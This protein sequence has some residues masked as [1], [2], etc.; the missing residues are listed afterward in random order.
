MFVKEKGKKESLLPLAASWFAKKQR[1]K[2]GVRGRRMC[3]CRNFL[4]LCYGSVSWRPEL[5][6]R[7]DPVSLQTG[8][9]K[10]PLTNDQDDE[11]SV[12]RNDAM[13]Y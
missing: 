5:D 1:N 4:A 13:E 12:A 9:T 2:G 8:L 6:F 7:I 10:S 11:R 3:L